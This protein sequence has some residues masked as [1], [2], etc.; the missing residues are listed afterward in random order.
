[1]EKDKVKLITYHALKTFIRGNDHE[2][3]NG[4]TIRLYHVILEVQFHNLALC[5]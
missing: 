1:M 3:K 2:N 4:V 5:F